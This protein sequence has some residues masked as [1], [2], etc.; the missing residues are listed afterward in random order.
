MHLDET[1]FAG[2]N[3]G[4]SASRSQAGDTANADATDGAGFSADRCVDVRAC[5]ECEHVVIR[6]RDRASRANRASDQLSL[7][8]AEINKCMVQVEDIL[9]TFNALAV[10]LHDAGLSNSP[11]LPRAARI[12]RQ[13]TAAFNSLDQISKRILQLPAETPTAK[14]LHLSI[15]RAVAQYLQLHMFP[16]TMLPKP[17]R[18]LSSASS[19]TS[20]STL[21]RTPRTP[22]PLRNHSTMSSLNSVDAGGAEDGSDGLNNEET[23][24]ESPASKHQSAGESEEQAGSPFVSMSHHEKLES[25]SVLRD[26]RERVK[27]YINEAQRE[28]RL[29]DAMSLQSSLKDLEAELAL[30]E[31]TL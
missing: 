23:V 14:R 10:R 22:T 15:R 4:P 16:L 31:Q 30:I 3:S 8:Y 11:D 26:Q 6:H 13:L 2:D 18:R 9:P 20:A 29:D 12:R 17:E 28:R 25:I 1:H 24:P 19:T 5:R 27:G 21:G 7:L